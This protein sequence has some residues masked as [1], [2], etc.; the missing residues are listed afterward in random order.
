[1]ESGKYVFGH[2]G[3]LA[4]LG[5]ADPSGTYVLY[6]QKST[7]VTPSLRLSSN[8]A[9]IFGHPGPLAHEGAAD[10]TVTHV[11]AADPT[12]TQGSEHMLIAD[13]HPGNPILEMHLN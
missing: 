7:L 9:T 3:P 12:V 5:A 6:L 10:P 11:R 13:V 2:P 1:M 8:P 4:H